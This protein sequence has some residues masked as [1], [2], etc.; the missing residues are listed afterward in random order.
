MT[1]STTHPAPAAPVISR[2]HVTWRGDRAFDA[3]PEGR[4]HRI[5]A[6][7]K[8]GPGPVETLLGAIATCS[9]IDIIDILAKRKTP[10]EQLEVNVDAERR[11]EFPRRV[12]R[13]DI[14]YR[15]DGAGIERVHAERAIAL[16]FERYC[17]VACSLA[18]D[19]VV[20]ARLTLNGEPH[21]AVRQRIWTPAS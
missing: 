9:G 6:G 11:S 16:S 1:D 19:I 21:P 4:T 3:G 12:Q 17:S 15:I 7:G 14:E 2:T 20:E 13:L 8:E 10:V 18:P 5:D